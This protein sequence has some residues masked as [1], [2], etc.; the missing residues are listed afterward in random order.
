MMSISTLHDESPIDPDDELLV[1]Y[2]DGELSREEESALENRLVEN[3]TLRD[4]LQTLQS[5]WDLLDDLPDSAPSLKLVESTLE[6][7]VADLEKSNNSKTWTL[8]SIQWPAMMLIAS[9]IGIGGAYIFSGS[10]KD[11]QYQREL[12]DLAI[13]ENLDAYL[14][15]R[16]IELMRLLAASPNWTSMISAGREIDEFVAENA[17]AVNETTLSEREEVVQQLPMEK[18][19]QLNL[20]WDRFNALSEEDQAAV[21]R[22][23]SAVKSQPDSEMLLNTMQSYAIW[24]QSLTAEQRDTI[25]SSDTL[26]RRAAIDEAIEQTQIAISQRSTLKLDEQATELIYFALQ[27]IV[28]N[29]VVNGQDTTKN[30][31][32]RMKERFPDV[33]DHYF[34]TIAAMVF[35]GSSRTGN[36]N[37]NSSRRRSSWFGSGERPSPITNSELAALRLVI[38]DSTLEILDL[39]AHGD[40][41]L[42]TITLRAWSEE[43]TRRH[44]P[45]KRPEESTYLERY[46]ATPSRDRDA[47]DLLPPKEILGELSRETPFP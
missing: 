36:S 18:L 32:E 38:P 21:R 42:E 25:E 14:R 26:A 4:R 29:R 17:N 23:A 28:R 3:E 13:A 10:L 41:L 2:L 15:G 39:I 1:S 12:D 31:L 9:L 44:F 6:L 33:E 34:G 5:G 35:S 20:R 40:P 45:M 37:N 47:L 22:T 19:R 30:H 43:A 8:R 16:D 7:V 46:I 27:Q 11:Y 24:S